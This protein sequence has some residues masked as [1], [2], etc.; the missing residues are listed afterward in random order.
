GY[1]LNTEKFSSKPLETCRITVNLKADGALKNVY[2]PSHSVNIAKKSASE[3]Q[4]SYEEKNVTPDKD[5]Y[6]YY[7]SDKTELGLN[8]LTYRKAGE[9]GYFMAFASPKH[10]EKPEPTPK[11]IVF[12]VDVSG[13]MRGDKI[14]QAKGA[15]QF[16]VDSLHE[17][18]RFNV[19]TFSNSV[20]KLFEGLEEAKRANI[21]R[22]REFASAIQA[23]GGTN[24]HDGVMEALGHFAADA[25]RP[26]YVV[27]LTDGMPTTGPITDPTGIAKAIR[28]KN[29]GRMRLFNFGV[30]HDVNSI[31]LNQLGLENKGLAE[32][33]APE[34]NIEAKVSSF[35]AK[36]AFPALT[37]PKLAVAGMEIDQ[38]YPR[39]IP[40][41]FAGG[42]VIVYGR[43]SADGEKDVILKGLLRGKEVSLTVKATF[44][45]A[46]TKHEFIPRFWA[47]TKIG[48]LMDQVRING[49]NAEL[50][51]EIVRLSKEFGIMTPYT[52][53]MVVDEL[54]KHNRAAYD[55][56]AGKPGAGAPPPPA[57]RNAQEGKS[58]TGGEAFKVA[59]QLGSMQKGEKDAKEMEDMQDASVRGAVRTVAGKTFFAGQAGKWID[60]NYTDKME[61]KKI[62]FD[63]AEYWELLAKHPTLAKHQSI[64]IAMIVIL[65]GQAYEITAK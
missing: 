47:M 4:I 46:D 62:V 63:S 60:G 17:S 11:D 19:L 38:V 20:N 8:V 50:R 44:A 21:V 64:G 61:L 42:Q 14:S 9:D 48:F 57:A 37:D 34:E 65:D 40:D 43:Y 35:Y 2:S 6:L 30:G 22:A 51:E 5:F 58:A 3:F 27:F 31:L 24:I 23:N 25:G 13:S 29:G 54:A 39:A 18:D 1:P 59:K 7:A 49:E 45:K 33:V 15:L 16:C 28:E 52:S 36:V 26:A 10:E 53:W 56:F 55:G 12:V 41:I 32:Y